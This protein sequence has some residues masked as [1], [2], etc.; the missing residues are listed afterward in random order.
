MVILVSVW[1][2]FIIQALLPLLFVALHHG[3]RR[4]AAF[5]QYRQIDQRARSIVIASAD[6]S[7]QQN[8]PYAPYN[9]YYTRSSRRHHWR[10]TPPIT[11][12]ARR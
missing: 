5:P 4:G 9:T 3:A 1:M 8:D 6:L 11:C 7:C 10:I 2:F 12:S